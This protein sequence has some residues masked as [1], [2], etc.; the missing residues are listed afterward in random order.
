MIQMN[1]SFTYPLV[2]MNFAL[3]PDFAVTNHG[4]II[5]MSMVPDAPV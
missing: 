5:I 2:F 3:I 1:G 4:T